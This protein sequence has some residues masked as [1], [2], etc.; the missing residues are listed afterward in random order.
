M[1][2]SAISPSIYNCQTTPKES[3]GE[4]SYQ[5]GSLPEFPYHH[6]STL[7]LTHDNPYSII[8]P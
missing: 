2:N 5:S 6:W 7:P 4:S 1:E 3:D 8:C